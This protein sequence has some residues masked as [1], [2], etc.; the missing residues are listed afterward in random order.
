MCVCVGLGVLLDWV[1]V[2]CV[3]VTGCFVECVCGSGC[4]LNVCV[5]LGVCWCLLDV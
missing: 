4:L 5:L 2:G 1:F 3:C